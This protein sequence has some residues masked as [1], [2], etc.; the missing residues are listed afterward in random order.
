MINMGSGLA[1]KE[2]W[3][4]RP[5]ADVATSDEKSSYLARRL[6]AS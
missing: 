1:P 4:V 6:L 3:V 2:V 5:R